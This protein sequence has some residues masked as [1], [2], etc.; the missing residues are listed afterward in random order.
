[1]SRLL[2]RTWC[3]PQ[4]VVSLIPHSLSCRILGVLLKGPWRS[5]GAFVH[6]QGLLTAQEKGTSRPREEA[7]GRAGRS[8]SGAEAR[9]LTASRS[10]GVPPGKRWERYLPG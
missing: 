8:S 1:M 2:G 9:G 6:P 5:L 4:S 10:S 3:C 7:P